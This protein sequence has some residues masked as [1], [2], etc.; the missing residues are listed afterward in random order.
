MKM[1]AESSFRNWLLSIEC[2]TGIIKSVL[3]HLSTKGEAER[4]FS[5]VIDSMALRKQS[6]YNPSK[7][8]AIIANWFAKTL[9]NLLR[10]LSYFFWC[11]QSHPSSIQL[12]T[13]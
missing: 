6:V 7:A 9:K 3:E 1:P 12:D 5:L 2:C 4:D 13:F 11:L 10:K 8:I